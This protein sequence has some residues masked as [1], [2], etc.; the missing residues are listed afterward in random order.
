M[1]IKDIIKSPVKLKLYFFV[2]A[3]FLVFTIFANYYLLPKMFTYF[4]SVYEGAIPSFVNN[5][6]ALLG[7]SFIASGFVWFVTPSGIGNSDV[8]VIASHDIKDALSTMLNKT[9][10]FS[11]YGHTARWNRAVTFPKILEQA[12]DLRITKH[13]DLII[14]DPDNEAACKLYASFGHADRKKGR[15]IQSITD[16]RI[17][18]LTTF[19]CCFE[20]NK[21]PFIEIDL[22]VTDRV[23]ISRFDISDNA[24]I[25]TKPYQGDPALYFP[26][27]TFFYSSY[28]EEFNIAKRQCK[29]VNLDISKD[30][31]NI[32]N[33]EKIF[34]DAGFSAGYIDTYLKKELFNTFD[35]IE[36]PY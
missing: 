28:K 17:E 36:K 21:S 4:G 16:V 19:L 24:L 3:L 9:E 31:V 5:L 23:S 34:K 10:R 22:Y 30:D 11:Y 26:K 2:L 8:N 20:I 12:K 7:S 14:I 35:K 29:K 25:L 6:I 18:L 15:K 13:I 27:N 33:L 1:I 32:E